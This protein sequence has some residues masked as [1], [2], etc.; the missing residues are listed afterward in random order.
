MKQVDWKTITPGMVCREAQM[1]GLKRLCRDRLDAG[2]EIRSLPCHG[3]LI[4]PSIILHFCESQ[5]MSLLSGRELVVEGA[6]LGRW[7]NAEFLL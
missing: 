7:L 6:R 2:N 5:K 3:H 1:D 4:F